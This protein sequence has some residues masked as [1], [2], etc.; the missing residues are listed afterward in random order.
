M[1]PAPDM[2]RGQTRLADDG[3]AAALADLARVRGEA[4]FGAAA[5]RFKPSF[6]NK[7]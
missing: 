3:P 6:S 1:Q 5:L 4:S 2:I 7:R